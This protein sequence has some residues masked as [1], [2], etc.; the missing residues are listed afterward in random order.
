MTL[1]RASTKKRKTKPPLVEISVRSCEISVPAI[2]IMFCA[3]HKS[4]EHLK[5]TPNT[6]RTKPNAAHL[7]TA[8]F[9]CPLA[10]SLETYRTRLASTFRTV[11]VTP[12]NDTIKM[13]HDRNLLKACYL[14]RPF[15]WLQRAGVLTLTRHETARRR[16]LHY[17][18]RVRAQAG[19]VDETLLFYFY[20]VSRSSSTQGHEHV[21]HSQVF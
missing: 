2:E 11:A 5:I 21:S 12:W 4:Y 19:L 10:H 15:P 17:C 7:M 1:A 13:V 6:M 9:H 8:P 16:V 20:Q 18:Y 3:T 14:G